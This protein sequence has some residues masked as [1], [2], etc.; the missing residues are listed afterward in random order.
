MIQ[1]LRELTSLAIKVSGDGMELDIALEALSE[2]LAVERPRRLWIHNAKGIYNEEIEALHSALW[3]R[4]LKAELKVI[5]AEAQ[6]P[7]G[8]PGNLKV[9]Y[10]PGWKEGLMRK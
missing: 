8:E 3:E 2:S 6:L 7:P 5:K 10:P 4:G 1:Q 9:I